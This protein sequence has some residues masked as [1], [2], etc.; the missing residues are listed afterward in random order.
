MTSNNQIT[1]TIPTQTTNQCEKLIQQKKIDA[2][3]IK[4]RE[5]ELKILECQKL[6]NNELDTMWKNHR[7][8][9][10]NY[11]MTTALIN[12]IDQR[13]QN[14]D[15]RSRDISEF[16]LKYY[17]RN[18]YQD[19]NDLIH[20]PETN[21][22][23]KRI[24]FSM[25]LI[26]DTFHSFNEKQLQLLNRGPSYVP[27][28]Q[29][30]VSSLSQSIDD[31]VKKLYAP[32]KHQ[33]N[34]LF[35]KH[36]VNLALSMEI[37]QKIKQQ[38]TELFSLWVPEDLRQR[39]EY[40]KH[41]IQCIRNDLVQK[42]LILR[43][44][45]DHMNTFYLGNRQDYEYKAQNYLTTSDAFKCVVTIT[46]DNDKLQQWCIEFKEMI[47]TINFLLDTL[48]SRKFISI[49]LYNR[50]IID[51]KKVI[52]PCADFLPDVSKVRAY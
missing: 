49:D 38:F 23:M 12:I 26:M 50:L 9:I 13:L 29:Q 30:T 41:L 37:Q 21:T 19:S 39:S 7:S 16:R 11:G 3:G 32:L 17:L 25:F 15:D 14:I 45:A 2:V 42:N 33:L 4:L 24:G 34:N 44:T 36:R 27:P 6:F 43:R 47:E 52:I 18:N 48:K 22:T 20:R 31:N 51:P 40:E 28:C 1:T 8:L 46:N 35:T 10:K 5:T